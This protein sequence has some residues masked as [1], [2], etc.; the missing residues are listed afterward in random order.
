MVE[1]DELLLVDGAEC[2]PGTRR[3]S[4]RRAARSAARRP[5][6]LG[7][8]TPGAEEQRTGHSAMTVCMFDVGRRHVKVRCMSRIYL[9]HNATTPLC[10]RGARGDDARLSTE[11]SAIRRRCTPRGG[12]RAQ[13]GRAGARRGGAARRR[14]ARGDRLHLGRHRGR[15]PGAARL[16][17]ARR[18]AS[19]SARSSIRRCWRAAAP[20]ARSAS[21]MRSGGGRP[22]R[23]RARRRRRALV[24]R[25]AGQPR[26]RQ[27]VADR[28][29]GGARARARRAAFTPTR[30][31]RRASCRSTCARSASISLSIS[32]H[33]IGGPKGV[34]AL[35]VRA[36]PRRCRRCCAAATRSASGGRGPRTWS[37]SSASARRRGGARARG[38]GASRA[39]RDRLRGG[40]AARSA[41]ACNGGGAPRVRN[42]IN[43][44]FDGV[45]GELL[46]AGARSRRASPSRRARPARSGSV[47]PSPVLLRARSVPRAGAR[48][49]RFSLGAGN[50]A[51]EI[52]RV[53]ALLPVAA[54]RGSGRA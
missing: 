28:R 7:R 25:A 49:V 53:L 13:R 1:L 52:D 50:T 27:P 47:E 34:G 31:R 29:V 8:R 43:L 4:R 44:A 45:A 22:R 10:T 35:W 37:A 5:G 41:R 46:V 18:D 48:R 19:T 6:L 54:S 12:A 40:R 36:R 42:T 39:L 16:A 20:G 17:R 51:D 32:A 26:D 38:G 30:C 15:Q 2:A 23:W 24:S 3:T 9:D 33:K 21:S 11:T 14:A